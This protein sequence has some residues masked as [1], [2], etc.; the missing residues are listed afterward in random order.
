VRIHGDGADLG[1]PR[2]DGRVEETAALRDFN[3]AYVADGVKAE[4]LDLSI[5]LD[6][7]FAPERWG[8]RPARLWIA[9]N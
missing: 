4:K 9:E 7:R 1:E 5:S 2:L 8:N 6:A 3:P